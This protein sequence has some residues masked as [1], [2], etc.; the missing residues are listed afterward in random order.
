[1][2]FL[3][4]I[5]MEFDSMFYNFIYL[6]K[7]DKSTKYLIHNNVVKDIIDHK[8]IILINSSDYQH[9]LKLKS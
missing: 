3:D 8:E 9:V 2:K 1:M 6:F 7:T 5:D 4:T